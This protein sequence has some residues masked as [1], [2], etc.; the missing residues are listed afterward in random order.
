MQIL[1]LEPYCTGSHRD[2][3]EG[4]ARASR[5]QVV[6]LTMPGQ[7]WKWR[8]YGGAVT[9]ARRLSELDTRPDLILATS[10]LDVATFLALSRQR[11][12]DIPV[13][14][15][16]HEN[17]LTYPMRPGEKR[18]LH[19]GLVNYTS[20]LAA[21]RV[22]FNSRF[23][24][25]AWFDELP[26]LLKHHA[27]FNELDTIPLLRG[28]SAVLPLGIDLASLDR[29]RPSQPRSGPLLI[30]WNHRWEYDKDPASLVQALD[31][32][33]DWG[34]EFEV[35]LLGERFVS[36]PPAFVEARERL[37]SRLVHY[38]YVPSRQAYARWLWEADVVVSTAIHDF[39]GAATVEA[40]YCECWPLLPNRLAYPELVPP[41]YHGRCLYASLDDLV[42]RLRQAAQDPIALRQ[43]ST[44]RS[45][46][47][48]YDWRRMAPQY[49][50]IL[51]EMVR[52]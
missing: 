16:M 52:H 8:M 26:R 51:E 46:V 15:Y 38:G 44:L 20:M 30:L 2:W 1:A 32:L 29:A 21:D 42:E 40:M 5:H 22:L 50:A 3:L 47:A 43:G 13:A 9:L 27:D 14:L 28:R 4:Y 39:F 25:E 7:F 33:M 49:D 45:A 41:E 17:Q 10:M 12:W 36:E 19:F 18:D 24:L 31:R 37:G 34:G 35:A 6:T 48:Q 23:H 11:T